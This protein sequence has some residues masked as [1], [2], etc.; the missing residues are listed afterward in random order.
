MGKKRD[1]DELTNILA[2]A[3]RHKIGSMVNKDEIYAQKYDKEFE[4]KPLRSV[5][6]LRFGYDISKAKRLLGYEPRYTFEQGLKEWFGEK[7]LRVVL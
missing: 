2:A 5:D 3:L 1:I 7:G 6:P 4:V